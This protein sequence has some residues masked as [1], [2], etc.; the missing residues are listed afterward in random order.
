VPAE[1]TGVIYD[2]PAPGPDPALLAARAALGDQLAALRHTASRLES[3]RH[4][5]PSAAPG[6]GWRGSAQSAY[7]FGVLDLGRRL[8]E[9]V[10]AVRTAEHCTGR[11]LA[12]LEARAG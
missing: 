11:A 9:A 8:D 3:T 6:G 7:R 5:I 10:D 12:T 4:A 1:N 2:I